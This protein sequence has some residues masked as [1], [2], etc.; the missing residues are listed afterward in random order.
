MTTVLPEYPFSWILGW[1]TTRSKAFHACRRRY[2]YQY[3]GIRHDREVSPARITYLKN[4]TTVPLTVGELTHQVMATLL[5]RM[6][7]DRSPIDRSR[8]EAHILHTVAGSLRGRAFAER[9][10]GQC[11]AIDGAAIG[12]RVDEHL[13]TYL[14]SERHRWIEA[15]IAEADR[16]IIDPEG[17]GEGRLEG[18]KIYA[19]V[20]L[21]LTHRGHTTILDW[22]TGQR[23][24]SS[25]AEQLLVYAA[26]AHET[27]DLPEPT[28]TTAMAY[29]SPAY[30]EHVLR[31][32]AAD[33]QATVDR[34]RRETAAMQACC[35]DVERNL[36]LE[37]EAFPMTENLQVCSGCPFRELCERL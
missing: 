17:Y 37:K 1:S 25:H 29:F 31:P 16:L 35:R 2:W 15:H 14:A 8:L 10:Y 34:V 26:W 33:L 22:K 28:I 12:R 5:H 6:E 24:V 3:Y 19:K 11:E 9:H 7:R 36:P 32:T 20:D 23:D 30:G 13:A 27:L 4:L 21:L 18:M